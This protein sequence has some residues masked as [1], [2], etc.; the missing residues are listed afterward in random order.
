MRYTT[1]FGLILIS[2]SALLMD[3]CVFE[4]AFNGIALGPWRGVLMLDGRKNQRATQQR[5]KYSL[6]VDKYT[7]EEVA[8]GELP[9]LM[10]VTHTSVDSFYIEIINGEER[11]K[12][13]TEHIAYGKDRRT[14][15]DTIRIDFPHYE[16]YISARYE[17]NVM[18]GD[19]VLTTKPDYR[20]PFVAYQGQSHRFTTLRKAPVMDISGKWAVNFEVETDHPYPA[21]GEFEQDG[22]YL[23]GT[24]LT[25][26]GDYRYLE[27]T[28]QANKI[29]LST[30]DG[31]H[32]F[33]FEGKIMEDSTLIGSF[34][35]GDHYRALWE[36]K[37]D[38]NAALGDAYNMTYL[39]D[40]YDKLAFSFP[41]TDGQ[42]ISLSD[43]DYEGKVR[44][45]Q[46]LG[47]W[48]P[49]CADE[50]AF[51]VEYLKNNPNE[52]LA[53]IGLA[54][55]RHRDFQKAANAVNR[56]KERFDM[57]Y[58]VLVAGTSAKDEAS[59]TLPMLNAII[60]FPTMIIIDKA[61]RVRKIHTGFAGPATSQYEDFKKEFEDTIKEL[62]NE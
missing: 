61:G 15:H 4:G 10:E 17:A 51:L 35:S 62:L 28:V 1:V 14:G 56:M 24:F 29:Y 27:G 49:N 52:D 12:I 37:R 8:E 48:C 7:F 60:A 34:R 9:F 50:T 20:I 31:T 19:Y 16:A 32:A 59:K 18:E 53:V 22:N 43:A 45:V 33:M 30:F 44:I 40:G 13:P 42:N 39:K 36:A 23:R 6:K 57:P 55:E 54:Y 26:T 25:E 5:D 11:V 41:N 46:I 58:E 47:T 21:V 3:S 38:P 2:I